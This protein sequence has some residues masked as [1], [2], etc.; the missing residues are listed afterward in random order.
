MSSSWLTKRAL[1][2]EPKCAGRSLKLTTKED[3]KEQPT[4]RNLSATAARV[5]Q[6]TCPVAASRKEFS[7]SPKSNSPHLSSDTLG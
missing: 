1:V 2:Y 4:P 7:A 5:L 3:I 6:C